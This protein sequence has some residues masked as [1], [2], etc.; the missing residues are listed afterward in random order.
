MDTES[1]AHFPE[2]RA[3]IAEL[4]SNA[5]KLAA[6]ADGIERHMKGIEALLRDAPTTGIA[7]A[8]PSSSVER[9]RG[10][11]PGSVSGKWQGVLYE[12]AEAAYLAGPFDTSLALGIIE[13]VI[14]RRMRPA[15]MKRQF[16]PYV[17]VGYL[18]QLDSGRYDFTDEGNRKVG[19][20]PNENRK[21]SADRDVENEGVA[22]PSFSNSNP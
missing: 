20:D 8:S 11:Q 21:A 14:G 12:L 16:E 3:K 10:K 17:A 1:P 18:R 19:F 7:A 15:E 2:L 22:P 5:A 13:R 9:K 4:R 6:Q